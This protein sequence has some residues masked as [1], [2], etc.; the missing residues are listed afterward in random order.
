M[1]QCDH[2]LEFYILHKKREKSRYL[3]NSTTDLHKIC[4]DDDDLVSLV[5]RSL[6]FLF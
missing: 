5:H 1:P 6:K 4:R 3:C 2:L